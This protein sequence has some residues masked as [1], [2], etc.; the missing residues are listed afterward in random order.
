MKVGHKKRILFVLI[1][2]SLITLAG[3][4]TWQLHSFRQ[5]SDGEAVI[6]AFTASGA[7]FTRME[8]NGW[9]VV[10]QIKASEVEQSNPKASAQWEM[11]PGVLVRLTLQNSGTWAGAG[12]PNQGKENAYLIVSVVSETSQYSSND[13]D[14]LLQDFMKGQQYHRSTIVSG[15]FKGRKSPPEVDEIISKML[16]EAGA[17]T[18]HTMKNDRLVSV[19]AFAPNVRDRLTLGGESVNINMAVRYNSVEDKT[20]VYVGS[21][22]ISSEY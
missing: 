10:D 1:I 21:P 5:E 14:Q 3:A 12:D 13:L 6:Q 15:Y 18:V 19:S 9:T 22:I 8:V 2:W 16:R 17:E 20:M 7:Q 4:F 11:K